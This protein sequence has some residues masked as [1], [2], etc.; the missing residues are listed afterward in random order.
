MTVEASGTRNGN[1]WYSMAAGASWAAAFWRR[2]ANTG[3][4]DHRLLPLLRSGKTTGEEEGSNDSL[5]SRSCRGQPVHIG[6]GFLEDPKAL[7]K[8]VN[9]L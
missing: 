5:S 8:R 3:T 1:E 6:Y 4:R 7:G 9:V 2:V